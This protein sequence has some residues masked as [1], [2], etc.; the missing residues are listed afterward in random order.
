[1]RY[2]RRAV[3][4]TAVVLAVIAGMSVVQAAGDSA[5][6]EAKAPA[7]MDLAK[8]EANTW[9]LLPHKGNGHWGNNMIWCPTR[10]RLLHY[11]TWT[12]VAFDATTG[13]WTGDYPWLTGKNLG[14]PNISTTR[15][16]VGCVGKGFMTPS[17]LPGPALS[18]NGLTWDSKRNRILMVTC[19]LMAAYDPETGKWEEIARKSEWD[20][21]LR[22]G[23]PLLYGQG[24]G[25]DPVHDEVVMFSHWQGARPDNPHTWLDKSR[26]DIDG[27]YSGHLGTL[28]F[29]FKDNTWRSV[30]D[31]LG[32]PEV[33]KARAGILQ[34]LKLTTTAFDQ[35]RKSLRGKGDGATIRDALS[36]AVKVV[37]AVKAPSAEARIGR[38]AE[39]LKKAAAEADAGHWKSVMDAGRDAYW[40]LDDALEKD[41]R[42]EPPARTGTPLVY[43]PVNQALVMFGGHGGALRT[44]L[45]PKVHKGGRLLG[46]NDTWVY[47]C[48]QR[49]WREI[50]SAAGPPPTLWPE[51]CYD[52]ASKR[53]IM[54]SATSGWHGNNA[55]I[56]TWF[57]DPAAEEWSFAGNQAA[58]GFL[59]RVHGG[60]VAEPGIEVGYDPEQRLLVLTTSVHPR[61]HGAKRKGSM[62]YV[63]RLD[64]SALTLRPAPERKTPPPITAK[65]IPADKPGW[66]AKLKGLPANTWTA[67]KPVGTGNT[68]DWGSIETDPLR[69]WVTYSGGGHSTYQTR[70]VAVYAVGANRWVSQAG[71]PNDYVPIVN[72]G[73]GGISFS[74]AQPAC[75]NCNYYRTLDGRRWYNPGVGHSTRKH[76]FYRGKGPQLAL[77]YDIDLGGVWRAYRIGEVTFE[78]GA[79]DALGSAHVADPAGRVMGFGGTLRPA[80]RDGLP[81]FSIFDIDQQTLV[82]RKIPKPYPA[83]VGEGRPFCYLPDK[84]QVFY[85]E[86][87]GAKTW[88]YDVKANRFTLLEP[89]RSPPTPKIVMGAEYVPEQNAVYT[90]LFVQKG[91]QRSQEEW[92]Y[93]FDRNDWAKLTTKGKKAFCR[94]YNQV[95]YVPRYGVLVNVR[96]TSIMRPDFSGLEWE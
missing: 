34:A 51:L 76:P 66:V 8:L 20:G 69:G 44:D 94:P 90:V 80:N 14:I 72:W 36:E 16:G 35:A 92:I 12:V 73:G 10:K 61:A 23:A 74:G 64:L 37:S 85:F 17:G 48:R 30:R 27:R 53:M 31:R 81:H 7:E 63:M 54:V 32:T 56:S 21:G 4:H 19:G 22:K 40:E 26:I 75:H 49:Q 42:V 6:G 55:R 28:V 67:A 47:D 89:R 60:N 24:V 78:N 96:G 52:P 13:S 5:G 86:Q 33:R 15:R 71:D 58:P 95:A 88:V 62:T 45:D 87:N 70:D 39:L 1:M 41:L 82:I 57:L 29:S 93:S 3:F 50:T 9:V 84:D 83:R 25:Y 43:D 46:L 18:I 91:K 11:N 2:A 38:A 77:F 68:R 65:P 79:A 59:G